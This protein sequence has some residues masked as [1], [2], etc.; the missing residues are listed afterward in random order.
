MAPGAGVAE[1]GAL[2]GGTGVPGLPGF[3]LGPA[4]LEPAPPG[5]ELGISGLGFGV[6][7]AVGTGAAVDAGAVGM[8]VPPLGAVA[9]AAGG[10]AFGVRSVTERA[11]GT[12]VPPGWAV[13]P[14]CR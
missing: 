12:E 9:G 13:A 14:P 1:G 4:G 3:G 5:L 6:G 8:G 7:T 10:T 2:G 11:S